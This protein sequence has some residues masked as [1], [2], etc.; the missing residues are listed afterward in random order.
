MEKS[1]VSSG[2]RKWPS[3]VQGEPRGQICERR[4]P[5]C[6]RLRGAVAITFQTS[7]KSATF[8][9]HY[10]DQAVFQ[11]FCEAECPYK[12]SIGNLAFI[13]EINQNPKKSKCGQA[14]FSALHLGLNTTKVSLR[15]T[16][17]VSTYGALQCLLS[18]LQRAP[19]WQSE[20][21]FAAPRGAS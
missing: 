14:R 15:R 1:L 21:I 4:L 6:R 19:L 20:S 3:S 5:A 17:F 7:G 2:Q 10:I 16:I 12:P 8:C 9:S 11:L 13:V 18:W